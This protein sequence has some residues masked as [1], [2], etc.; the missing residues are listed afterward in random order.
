MTSMKGP[1]LRKRS[2]LLGILAVLACVL[3]GSRANAQTQ[4][5]IDSAYKGD[6]P[7]VQALLA[8]GAD[9]N[10]AGDHGWTPLYAACLGNHFDVVQ[11]LLAHKVDVD[12]HMKNGFTPLMMA[13]EEV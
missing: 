5:L 11:V 8:A 2:F 7:H 10:G 13:S 12:G 1:R 4:D 6:L 3:A 9:V